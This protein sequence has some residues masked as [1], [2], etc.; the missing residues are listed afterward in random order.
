MSCI[1]STNIS[2]LINGDKTEPFSPS[3]GIHQGDPISPY[4]FILCLEYLSI[5]ISTDMASRLWKG[6]K[7]SKNG[8]TLSHLFSADDLIFVGKASKENCQ[9]LKGV[10]DFFCRYSGKEINNDKSRVLFS[11]N[12]D[13][14]TRDSLCSLLGLYYDLSKEGYKR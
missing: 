5:K 8:P 11:R 14:N 12:V 10:L 2:I 1:S 9:Y 6:N 4:I 7:V 13:Q 3:R